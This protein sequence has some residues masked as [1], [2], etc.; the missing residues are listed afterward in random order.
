[1]LACRDEGFM[2]APARLPA[3]SELYWCDLQQQGLAISLWRT[4]YTLGNSLSCWGA[5]YGTP[6][7]QQHNSVLANPGTGSFI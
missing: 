5:S 3:F 1:M 2:E 4:N 6:F 7:E